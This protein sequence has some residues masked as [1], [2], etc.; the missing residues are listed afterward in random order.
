MSAILEEMTVGQLVAEHP[1]RARVFERWGIDY[2][3]GGKRRLSA[4]CASK[5]ADLSEVLQ[6]LKHIENSASSSGES[7]LQMPLTDL[8]DDIERTHHDYLRAELPRL[9][10]LLERVANRHGENHPEMVQVLSLFGGFRAELELHMRKEE[11][12]L[13]P[14][15]RQLDE[16]TSPIAAHCGSVSN[17][18]RVMEDE[19]SHAGDALE[20]MRV[21]TD[22]FMPPEGACNTFRVVL[23]SLEQLEAD[24]HLHVHKENNVLFPRAIERETQLQS[25]QPK[26]Y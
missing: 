7:L 2:C 19:H 16:A 21:L 22:G 1:Q 14:L 8:C 11:V 15:I 6:A 13:F 9:H 12:I 23:S 5:G 10:S 17:P 20:Q 18:I 25:S 3:C 24:M 4:A 26:F